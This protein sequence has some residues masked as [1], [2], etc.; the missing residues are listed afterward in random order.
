MHLIFIIKIAFRGRILWTGKFK[1]LVLN[2][3]TLQRVTHENQQLFY[4]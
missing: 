2:I 4:L 1:E 3:A